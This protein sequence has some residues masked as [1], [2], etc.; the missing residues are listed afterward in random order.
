MGGAGAAAH[1]HDD[2]RSVMTAHTGVSVGGVSQISAVTYAT[3]ML[4]ITQNT[5]FLLLDMRDPEDYQ[6]YHIKEAINY[7]APNIGRDKIIPELF[8]FKNQP[9]K[10]IIIYM[11]DERKGTAV[12][13]VFF[14]KGYEN[15]YLLSGGIEQFTEE[16]HELV[17][18]KSVPTPK[19]EESKQ[20][21]TEVT[22]KKHD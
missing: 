11:S 13:Q 10:L 2:A 7:P 19:K 14:E 21:S 17:E 6:L 16:F 18:G 5:K 4:G 3:E 20:R 1:D 8:R 9:D 12:A 15:V 22:K